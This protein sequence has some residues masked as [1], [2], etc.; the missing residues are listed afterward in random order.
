MAGRECLFVQS[1]V[2]S[3]AE[4]ERN[5]HIFYQMLAGSSSDV[6][7]KFFQDFLVCMYVC[8][9]VQSRVGRTSGLPRQPQFRISI[10][11]M[12]GISHCSLLTR[13]PINSPPTPHVDPAY[14]HIHVHTCTYMPTVPGPP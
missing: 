6:L 2:V 8:M 13:G 9:Y 12:N 5:F 7:R 11:D 14:M 10:K 3:Q 4:G 1:R